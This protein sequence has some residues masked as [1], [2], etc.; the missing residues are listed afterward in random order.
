MTDDIPSQI[1]NLQ[2]SITA[3]EAQRAVLGEVVINAALGSMREKLA[4]L[5]AALRAPT[6]PGEAEGERKVVTML[7]ADISGFTAL[8]ETLD[9]EQVTEIVNTCFQTLTDAVAKYGGGVDKYIGDAIMALFGAPDAHEDDPERAIHAALEMQA[10]LKTTVSQLPPVAANLTLH[11]GVN[12]GPVVAGAVGAIGQRDYTVMGDA[13]NL[14]S[15][16]KDTAPSG[17]IYVGPETYRQTSRLFE[18]TPLAPMRIKGKRDPVQIYAVR[19]RAATPGTMRGIEG[20]RSPLIGRGPELDT[21]R[22]RLDAAAQ[23]NGCVVALVGDAG[24]G[25]SRLIAELHQAV[26]TA[27]TYAGAA[28]A[29]RSNHASVLWLEGRCTSFTQSVSYSLIAQILR[30]YF[31]LTGE[32]D[33]SEAL[34]RLLEAL[35][36]VFPG[37][38]DELLPYL[39]TLLGLPVGGERTRYLDAE[40]LQRQIFYS[41]RRLIGGLSLQTP[42]V[43]VLDDLHWIDETSLALLE[44]LLPLVGDH[45]LLIVWA[46]RPGVEPTGIQRLAEQG[47]RHQ[48]QRIEQIELRPLPDNLSASLVQLLLARSNLPEPIQQAIIERAEGNPFYLEEVIRTLIESGL[49]IQEAGRWVIDPRIPDLEARI[50]SALPDTLIGVLAARIDRLPELPK[51][52]LGVASVVGRS[53]SR[54]LMLELIGAAAPL[55]AGLAELERNGLIE[56]GEATWGPTFTFRHVLTQEAAYSMLLQRRRTQL[57][58]EIANTL[59][60]LHASEL[61]EYVALLA[62]HYDRS[63][64]GAKASAYLQ[65]AGQAALRVYA[66]REAARFFERV[67]ERLRAASQSAEQLADA[68]EWL[69]DARTAA[70]EVSAAI[71]HW[72][73]SLVLHRRNGD[74]EGVALL[75]RKLG[76]A[77]FTRGERTRAIENYQQGIEVLKDSTPGSTLAGLYTELGRAYFRIGQDAQAIAWAS[78]ALALAEALGNP[79]TLSLAL[80]TLGVAH[81]RA[82]ELE[83]GSAEVERSLHIALDND[84]PLAA[85]RA[86]TN[87]GMLYGAVDHN[88]AVQLCQQGLALARKIGDLAYQSW[89]QAS[90]ASTYCSLVGNWERGVAAA[91]ASIDLDLQMGHRDHLAVPVVLLAQIYQ[92][93]GL[94]EEALRAYQEALALAE[95]SGEPQMLFPCYNGLGALYLELGEEEEATRYLDQAQ[96]IVNSAGYSADSLFVLPFL[97]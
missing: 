27:N 10:V 26:H 9:P 86:Y 50:R 58:G 90:L 18:F 96:A 44:Y 49:L 80:N 19:A 87:L 54:R 62:Y 93:H 76:N 1:A 3:L 83:R 63:Q 39:G 82:G 30:S 66:N 64:D 36:A 31:G 38:G 8:S 84:R 61:D 55:D 74:V 33:A 89:L 70:G 95:E 60:R 2:A 45:P 16:L 37:E 22:A 52:V 92:C 23:G 40:A 12:T 42:L 53:F 59:E 77:W 69:G 79:G 43:L 5:E 34:L 28:H 72:Q 35:D 67:V 14:A 71:G 94:L 75:H 46:F 41:V 6:L 47:A 13:V 81:A 7:F 21:L 65:R 25:K 32:L 56:S 24:L 20:L 85:C 48:P 97:A 51:R 29:H 78:Q 88:K 57:H 15:R 91:R 68:L 11:I 4:A 17:H 73:E